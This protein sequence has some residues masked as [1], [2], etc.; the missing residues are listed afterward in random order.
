[1]ETA[2]KF[3]GRISENAESINKPHDFYH[4][5]IANI[6]MFNKFK[7]KEISIRTSFIQTGDDNNGYS[8]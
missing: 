8:T 6:I 2:T 3:F 5:K 7:R 4:T 1:V